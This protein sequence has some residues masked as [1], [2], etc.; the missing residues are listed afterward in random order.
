MLLQWT[1]ADSATGGSC[2]YYDSAVHE[3]LRPHEVLQGHDLLGALH[4]GVVVEVCFSSS[5][6]IVKIQLAELVT[7]CAASLNLEPFS[8]PH[9]RAFRAGTLARLSH[10]TLPQLRHILFNAQLKSSRTRGLIQSYWREGCTVLHP[11]DLAPH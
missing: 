8:A 3:V 6:S 10:P 7:R 1:W 11:R 4:L 5:R 9:E 2:D